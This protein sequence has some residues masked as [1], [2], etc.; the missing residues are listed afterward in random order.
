M[1]WI[2]G[3]SNHPQR[4]HPSPATT[5]LGLRREHCVPPPQM[6]NPLFWL[7]FGSDFF[8]SGEFL[9]SISGSFVRAGQLAANCSGFMGFDLCGC[10]C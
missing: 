4:P 8:V 1:K 10:S 5:R 9:D 6:K 3:E 7:D 2:H